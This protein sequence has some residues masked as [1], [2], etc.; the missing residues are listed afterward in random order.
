MST[1][2]VV[3][4]RTPRH[5][6]GMDLRHDPTKS[7]SNMRSLLVSN[8]FCRD[9]SVT[10]QQTFTTQYRYILSSNISF[11][12]ILHYIVRRKLSNINHEYLI[13]R[14]ASLFMGWGAVSGK[15]FHMVS[16]IV[17]WDTLEYSFWTPNGI[18]KENLGVSKIF[19][20]YELGRFAHF[21]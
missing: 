21:E 2:G 18:S 13:F 15:R 5:G 1:D 10:S 8:L 17:L 3:K 6:D 12:C 9:R 11:Y 4:S 14:E 16:Q 7:M 19:A 20:H